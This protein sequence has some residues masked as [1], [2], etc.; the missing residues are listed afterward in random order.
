M[1]KM[2][3]FISGTI[4]CCAVIYIKAS[5]AVNKFLPAAFKLVFVGIKYGDGLACS[6]E[7][8][9]QSQ[10]SKKMLFHSNIYFF[11]TSDPDLLYL[12]LICY[13]FIV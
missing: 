3:V 9:K 13:F 7:C 1:Q 2:S 10:G 8:M 5:R 4:C 11:D 6:V 12:T